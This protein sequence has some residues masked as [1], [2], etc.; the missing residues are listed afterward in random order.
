MGLLPDFPNWAT[1][2]LALGRGYFSSVARLSVDVTEF[3]EY[4]Q[5]ARPDRLD[6][7]KA[8]KVAPLLSSECPEFL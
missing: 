6:A 2:G 1:E 5:W 8:L 3:I 7:G 4:Q